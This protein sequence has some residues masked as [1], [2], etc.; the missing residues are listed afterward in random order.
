MA[1]QVLIKE[2]GVG[3][4]FTHV[5][6]EGT[7][8]FQP[9]RIFRV[10]ELRASTAIIENGIGVR[11]SM[12]KKTRVLPLDAAQWAKIARPNLAE[13]IAPPAQ[14]AKPAEQGE[15]KAAG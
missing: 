7:T 10:V 9:E 14:P 8:A 2:L 11:T 12:S 15:Q 3:A 5:K 13:P 6:D 1:H 4:P